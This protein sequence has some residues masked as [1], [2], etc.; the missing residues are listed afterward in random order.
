MNHAPLLKKLVDHL[1]DDGVLLFSCGG[2]TES[3]EHTNKVM[4]PEVYYASL[5]LHGYI[6]LLMDAGCFVRHVEFDQH[7]E[8]HTI[9]IVQKRVE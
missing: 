6:A 3:G 2:T 8:L 9:I 1:V 7:P 5:G 4:G